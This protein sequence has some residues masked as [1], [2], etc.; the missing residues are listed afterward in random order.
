LLS[1]SVRGALA[2]E[3]MSATLA[4]LFGTMALLLVAVGLYGVML[5]QVAERTTEIGIRMALGARP[6]SVVRLVLRDSFIVAA[7]GVVVGL[8]LALL[9]GRAVASQLYGVAPYSMGALAVA[10][11][12]LVAVTLVA[13]LVPVWRAVRI[14]P[15]TALRAE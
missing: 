10:S 1:V 8:P 13:S 15:L 5:Y 4:A 12:C 3:R 11:A 9:A 7:A 2:R 6:E 14:D